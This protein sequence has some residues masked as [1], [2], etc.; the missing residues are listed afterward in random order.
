MGAET[1]LRWGI[2]QSLVAYIEKLEDGATELSGPVT[3][4]DDEFIFACDDANAHFNFETGLGTLQFE[5]TVTFTGHWG[6]MRIAIENPRLTV[7]AAGA[8]LAIRVSSV[9]GPEAFH[10]F[11]RVNLVRANDE[12]VGT[13]SLLAGGVQLMGPQYHEGQE[14]SPLTVSLGAR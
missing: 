11:A 8:E 5:G 12:L 2:K 14:L 6:G 7:A 13:V 3:R 4:S 10:P 9:F 1:T